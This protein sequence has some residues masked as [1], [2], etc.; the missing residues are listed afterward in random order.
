MYQ[1]DLAQLSPLAGEL[2]ASDSTRVAI[3][4]F[5]VDSRLA[6]IDYKTEPHA[7]ISAYSHWDLSKYLRAT[8]DTL[9]DKDLLRL[10]VATDKAVGRYSQELEPIGHESFG[11]SLRNNVNFNVR[12]GD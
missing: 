6:C 12:L 4:S 7:F 1:I 9:R 8:P 2:L 3:K 5:A 10:D 11:R